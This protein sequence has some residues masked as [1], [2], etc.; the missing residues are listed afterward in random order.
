MELLKRESTGQANLLQCK[1]M[2]IVI[3]GAT[4]QLGTDLVKEL[5]QYDVVCPSIDI[6]KFKE[7]KESLTMIEPDVVINTAAYHNTKLTESH[8]KLAFKTN[9][10][11]VKNLAETCDKLGAS[12]VQIST[13]CVFDGAK[14]NY[15]ES[16]YP[17]PISHYGLS[18]YLGE[19]FIQSTFENYYI[20]RTSS[21]FGIKGCEAKGGLN[22][23]T[24]MLKLAK[25]GEIK[26]KIDEFTSITYT[27]DLAKAIHQMILVGAYGVYHMSN[28]GRLSW[29][30]FAT[31]V[32][33]LTNTEAE[34]VP[35]HRDEMVVPRPADSSLSTTKIMLPHWKDALKRFIEE[36]K[37]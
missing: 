34:V 16:D 11:A 30:D 23:P 27:K 6:D 3:L 28:E 12:L 19:R 4:G 36:A 8:P 35:I 20:V 25:Q 14:G 1:P 5:E 32:F 18:K 21:L 33:S 29:F 31:E 10:F 37:L 15:A 17:N 13:D 26:V 9:S 2:K 24:L 7:V 22:F